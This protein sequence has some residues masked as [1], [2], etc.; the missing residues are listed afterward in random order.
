VSH[1][2]HPFEGFHK[3]TIQERRRRLAE[4]LAISEEELSQCLDHGGLQPK[5][6]DKIVENVL[7]TYA[8]PFGVAP[9]FVINGIK[10]RV[11]MV[12]EEP[13]VIAAASSAAKC[14]GKCGGFQAKNLDD[15]MTVQIE[16]H[17]V[18][19]VDKAR[20]RVVAA[21][22]SL[23]E[24]AREL[25]PGLVS[26]GGGP[27]ELEV[28]SIGQGF[29]VVHVYVDC[30]D[31]MGANLVNTIAEGIGPRVAEL[32][33]G[34]LGLRILTNLCDRRRVFVEC[35][36]AA[37]TLVK[38][39]RNEPPLDP[40]QLRSMGLQIAGAIEQASRFAE[41]DPYRAATH[42]KGIMNGID[43]VVIAT[44]N[45]YRAVEAGA[46][47]YAARSGTYRP[48]TTWRIEGT[49]LCGRIELPMALG[50][51]GGTLRVHPAAKLA[52]RLL[53]VKSAGELSQIAASVGLASNFSALRALAT[54]GIQKGHMAL[55]YR[56]L[57]T[58]AGALA[59]EVEEVAAKLARMAPANVDVARTLLE[60]LRAARGAI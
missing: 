44:G 16:V 3:L 14:V 60:Q 17:A 25:V 59:D 46:H 28:R 48:L 27:R 50:I 23:L 15:W 37:E 8:L 49:E 10:R 56:G 52:L 5:T 53:G 11:P 2:K 51:V 1:S 18:T 6:A 58:L 24:Q 9:H 57:A 34:T 26:R 19:D 41:L 4:D 40:G 20:R 21:A 55:H 32:A 43:S 36:L 35:R 38:Q 29:V 22:E 13:S 45:D 47:A 42:N 39:R 31:A 54:E 7:G 12:V 30:L 33:E